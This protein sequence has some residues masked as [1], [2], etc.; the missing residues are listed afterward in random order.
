MA[1]SIKA[2]GDKPL[3]WRYPSVVFGALVIVAM[4]LLRSRIVWLRRA[5]RLP[6][7]R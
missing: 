2:F 3:G 7:P 6:P 1:L 4:Y 5:R